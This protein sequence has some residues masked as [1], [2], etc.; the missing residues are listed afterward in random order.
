MKFNI[1]EM[2]LMYIYNTD[3]KDSLIRDLKNG[4]NE[5]SDSELLEIMEQ[6]I[7]KLESLTDEEFAG[8]SFYGDYD[9]EN[10]E[11]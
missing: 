5:V 6:T 1:E 7:I 11:E 8:I 2:N 4:L 9:D 3:T 10:E